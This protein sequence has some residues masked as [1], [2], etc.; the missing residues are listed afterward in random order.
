VIALNLEHLD[1][2]P[3]RAPELTPVLARLRQV[4]AVV[5]GAAAAL[6]LYLSC[7]TVVD[8]IRGETGDFSPSGAAAYA[9]VVGVIS[10]VLGV[11]AWVA[12]PRRRT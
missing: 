2:P 5:L 8:T 10:L 3:A 1:L 9:A 6:F 11:G 12:W 7:V 4:V